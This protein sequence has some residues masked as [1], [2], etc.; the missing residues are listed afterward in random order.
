MRNNFQ[1]GSV[2][3]KTMENNAVGVVGAG[4]EED[5]HFQDN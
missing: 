4:T 1:G 5:K 2:I 3:G